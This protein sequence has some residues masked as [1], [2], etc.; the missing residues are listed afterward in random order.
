[1]ILKCVMDY[2]FLTRQFIKYFSYANISYRY[3]KYHPTVGTCKKAFACM[4]N[5]DTVSKIYIYNNSLQISYFRYN[6]MKACWNF[7]SDER[8]G[9]ALLVTTIGQQLTKPVPPFKMKRS[10]IYLPMH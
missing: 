1:M 8:P 10:E 3:H 4:L 6:V 5:R 9:F 7:V 2:N